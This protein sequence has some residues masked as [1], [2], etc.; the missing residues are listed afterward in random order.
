MRPAALPR[1]FD[2]GKASNETGSWRWVGLP[3]S[4]LI[5]GK[6]YFG[7]CA[8]VGRQAEGSPRRLDEA[9][10]LRCPAHGAAGG[11]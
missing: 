5:N 11:K 1:P 6:G 2:A 10:L 8:I 9:H 4:L 7:D 3:Q